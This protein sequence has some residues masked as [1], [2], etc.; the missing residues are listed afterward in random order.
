VW[1]QAPLYDLL[2]EDRRILKLPFESL[3]ERKRKGGRGPGLG[4]YDLAFPAFSVPDKK[5]D[6]G[7]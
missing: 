1:R 2:E 3:R 4:A 7:E 5:E 6:D